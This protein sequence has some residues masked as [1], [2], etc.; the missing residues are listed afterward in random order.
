MSDP[1]SAVLVK[2]TVD[3][4]PQGVNRWC[5]KR[6]YSGGHVYSYRDLLTGQQYSPLQCSEVR[7]ALVRV[8]CVEAKV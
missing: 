5:A 2:V 1:I 6:E 3:N 8:E 4:Y 7:E